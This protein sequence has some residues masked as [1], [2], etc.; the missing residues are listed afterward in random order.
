MSFQF[1]P[2]QPDG[3]S[4][5]S[6]PTPTHQRNGSSS[7]PPD[8]PLADAIPE[9]IQDRCKVKLVFKGEKEVD[10]FSKFNKD[11]EPKAN[12][13]PDR[14]AHRVVIDVALANLEVVF[15]HI[16]DVYSDAFPDIAKRVH[17]FVRK[18]LSS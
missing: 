16:A 17:A 15:T 11:L 1:R 10:Y 5:P 2:I 7:V 9:V 6:T 13:I 4:P 14:L 3:F 18:H 8:F 12:V